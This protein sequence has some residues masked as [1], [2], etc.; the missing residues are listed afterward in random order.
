MAMN[1]GLT[2]PKLYDANNITH[3]QALKDGYSAM[4]GMVANGDEAGAQAFYN[5]KQAQYGFTDGEFSR[6]AKNPGLTGQYSAKAIGQ[7]KGAQPAPQ[8]A[9]QP[10]PSNAPANP[11]TA[12]AAT[13]P[14]AAPAPQPSYAAQ[15][16]PQPAP[17]MQRSYQK[18]PYLD[19]M[20]QG[21]TSQMNDNWTRNLQPS[22]RSGAVAAGGFGG[23]RQGVVEANGLNDMNR[24]LGQNL[25]NLYNSDYQAQMG[26]NLQEYQ[27]NQSYALGQGNLALGNKNSD[28]SYS[29]G[30]GQLALGNK[31]AGNSYDLG[32]R[33][34]DLGFAGLDANINQNNFNNQLSG[35]Q[36]GL[37][38]YNTLQNGNNLGLQVSTQIQN[39]PLEYQKYFSDGANAAGGPGGSN[40][41]QMPGNA[42]T[43]AMGGLQL[44]NAWDNNR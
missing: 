36:F 14:A 7:W 21:I 43:G 30:Q 35:A 39:Q 13:A 2:A 38:A 22:M 28:Q 31:Q 12:P 26:R 20:A 4:Q 19:D 29:L 8:A 11:Y 6:Y 23:S 37:N 34:S 42:L 16:A 40:S 17:Q 27:G 41:Q 18:S 33:S 1:L 32:L 9:Q 25:S 10:A 44:Y 24:S 15:P 3:Q 5:Q